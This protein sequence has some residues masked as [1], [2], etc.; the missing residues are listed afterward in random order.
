MQKSVCILK[1][2]CVYVCMHTC[3]KS[4][5]NALVRKK[6]SQWNCR[7]RRWWRH[8]WWK[9]YTTQKN[10]TLGKNGR[11][12]QLTLSLTGYFGCQN[13]RGH[14]SKAKPFFLFGLHIMLFWKLNQNVSTWYFLVSMV[15]MY[16]FLRWSEYHFS[17]KA[18]RKATVQ[19]FELFLPNEPKNAR[20]AFKYGYKQRHLDLA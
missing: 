18:P 10:K 14:L 4:R 13:S 12:E 17:Q 5:C 15:T 8:N 6:E 16:S 1:S 9:H 7:V 19:M 2:V 3:D 11:K 20:I